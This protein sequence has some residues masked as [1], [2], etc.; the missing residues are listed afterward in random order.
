VYTTL[1]AVVIAAA[2]A[3]N[4]KPKNSTFQ[5][6]VQNLIKSKAQSNNV[7]PGASFFASIVSGV[8]SKTLLKVSAVSHS[9]CIFFKLV[10][11][12]LGGKTGRFIGA[13]NNWFNVNR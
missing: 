3:Y 5:P 9:D 11:C 6:Y 13:F 7:S 10:T 2:I 4:N 1:G 8:V 12:K